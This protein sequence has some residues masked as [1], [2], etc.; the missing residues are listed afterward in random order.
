MF[1]RISLIA[2]A[3]SAVLTAPAARAHH[4]FE[5]TAA[6]GAAA[7]SRLGVGVE[8]NRGGVGAALTPMLLIEAGIRTEL[9]GLASLTFTHQELTFE[10]VPTGDTSPSA[11]LGVSR[12]DLTLGGY[13]EHTYGKFVPYLGA[14][15]GAT[16][17]YAG[18]FGEEYRPAF[19]L[20][21]GLKYDLSE[22]VQL[23]LLFRGPMTLLT[24]TSKIFC[25]APAGC[26]ENTDGTPL[27]QLQ[28]LLGATATF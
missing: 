5:V 25:L 17:F 24:S 27:L 13:L 7:T 12:S 1:R 22:F 4:R 3:C 14:Q 11:I 20:D 21:G 16:R 28:G 6:L 8:P 10:L 15:V 19:V 9:D 26:E 2:V 18:G 23:R